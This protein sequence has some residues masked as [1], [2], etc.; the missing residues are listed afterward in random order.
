MKS[1]R[2]E[3]GRS[4]EAFDFYEDL[5]GANEHPETFYSDGFE[6][7]LDGMEADFLDDSEYVLRFGHNPRVQEAIDAG[8]ALT[9]EEYYQ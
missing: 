9:R 7:G 5:M 1:D 4:D 2:L 3:S 8:I 6:D